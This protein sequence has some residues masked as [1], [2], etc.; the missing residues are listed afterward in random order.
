MESSLGGAIFVWNDRR[1]GYGVFA[2]FVDSSGVRQWGEQDVALSQGW[3]GLVSFPWES[4]ER[5]VAPDEA[6]GAFVTWFEN[7]TGADYDAYV[8]HAFP[9]G[10]TPVVLSI[11]AGTATPDRVRITWE[12]NLT[13]T[14]FSVE[15]R[16]WASEWID[17]GR[18]EVASNRRL[19]FEDHDVAP[20][21]TYTYRLRW[22]SSGAETFGG[23]FTVHTPSAFGFGIAEV[24]PLTG[25]GWDISLELPDR[26]PAVLEVMDVSGRRIDRREV[27]PLGSGL[28][29]LHLQAPHA[30]GVYFIRLSRANESSIRKV[31]SL[32]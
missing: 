19:I 1:N 16:E 12:S 24:S 11:Q 28:H 26:N 5:A 25:N 31:A 10:A 30:S 17:R 2:Q 4:T 14:S 13:A 15:R 6:G 27:G 18:V 8:G 29:T 3:P 21:R 23:E 9:D 32:R 7:R 22:V 20:D